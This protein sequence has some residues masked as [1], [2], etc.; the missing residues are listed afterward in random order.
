MPYHGSPSVQASGQSLGVE[1]SESSN[2]QFAEQ[3]ILIEAPGFC[4]MRR[5]R[6]AQG[7]AQ[8]RLKS[9][10]SQCADHQPCIRSHSVGGSGFRLLAS[11]MTIRNMRMAGASVGNGSLNQKL[12]LR[13]VRAIGG[14]SLSIGHGRSLRNVEFHRDYHLESL[15]TGMTLAVKLSLK[16]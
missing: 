9:Q 7:K 8:G 5:F 3:Q 10:R 13:T 12:V 14:Y 2:F 6:L 16:K 11:A 1:C 4:K 15:A